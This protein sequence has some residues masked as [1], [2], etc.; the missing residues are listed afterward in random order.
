MNV[1]N[2]QSF[3]LLLTVL[4][5]SSGCQTVDAERIATYVGRPTFENPCIANG[6]GTCFENGELRDT[7][8]MICGDV[9]SY[10]EVQTH[11]ENVELR[12]YTC[13]RSGR[14]CK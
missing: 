2:F 7:T 1:N 13:L 12:L 5:L 11:L 9:D 14:R 3:L 4:T 10:D 6:D 8:N